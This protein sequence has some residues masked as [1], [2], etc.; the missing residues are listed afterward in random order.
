MAVGGSQLTYICNETKCVRHFQFCDVCL[1][2]LRV[3]YSQYDSSMIDSS[4][5]STLFELAFARTRTKH[6]TKSTIKITY[7][8][9]PSLE[10]ATD[11]SKKVLRSQSPF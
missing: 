7:Y 10:S 4:Y 2:C 11:S 5:L 3:M 8:L 9:L 6:E 1:T